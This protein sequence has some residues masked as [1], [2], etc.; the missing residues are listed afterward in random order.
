MQINNSTNELIYK[1]DSQTWKM[2]L[3]LPNGK[4]GWVDDKLG[5]WD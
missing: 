2:N 1:T 4:W 5:V 3:W